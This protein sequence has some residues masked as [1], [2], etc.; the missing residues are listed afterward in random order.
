MALNGLVYW[1]LGQIL[2]LSIPL[3]K[4]GINGITKCTITGTIILNSNVSSSLS[5]KVA[6][7][8]TVTPH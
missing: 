3:C 1:F 7:P 6:D 8:L 5:A 2:Y 4:E